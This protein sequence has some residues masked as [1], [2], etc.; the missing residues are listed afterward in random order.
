MNELER[1]VARWI[2]PGSSS[3]RVAEHLGPQVPEEVVTWFGW[4]GGIEIHPG[5][6]QGSTN[7]IPGYAPVSL[8]EAVGLKPAYA[9][10][11][12]LGEHWVP[13]LVGGGADMYAA[14]WE[15]GGAPAVAGVLKGEP[16]EVEFPSLG[17]MV[18]FFNRCYSAGAFYVRGDGCLETDHEQQ[19][20][21]YS[22]S[23]A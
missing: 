13:V 14:V 6:D 9:G 8:D 4:C 11:P 20:E 15:P 18:S 5:Q 12:V 7:M 23:F 10:D 22:E 1:P 2:A 17:R 3:S 21:L 16:T 19:D